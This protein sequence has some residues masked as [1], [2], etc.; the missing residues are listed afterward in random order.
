MCW[1]S[2]LRFQG[3]EIKV[4][5]VCSIWVMTTASCVSGTLFFEQSSGMKCDITLAGSQAKGK[6]LTKAD[7][8]ETI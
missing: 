4:K 3:K 8:I 2:A 7:I 6:T 1:V 5:L